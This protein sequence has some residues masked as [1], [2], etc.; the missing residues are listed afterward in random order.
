M[1]GPIL[2]ALREGI[3]QRWCSPKYLKEHFLTLLQQRK[4]SFE[5]SELHQPIYTKPME[6]DYSG[7]FP[8]V[9]I[10]NPQSVKGW[11]STHFMKSRV[12]ST[13]FLRSRLRQYWLPEPEALPPLG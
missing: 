8:L 7:A 12:G 9:V 5:F 2:A 3:G 4:N 10:G 11:E 13:W 6:Q 1:L